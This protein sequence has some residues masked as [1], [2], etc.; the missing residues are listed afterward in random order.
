MEDIKYPEIAKHK[1]IHKDLLITLHNFVNT[2]NILTTNEIQIQLYQFID[3]YFVH[4]IMKEDIKIGMWMNPINT[5]RKTKKWHKEYEIGNIKFDKECQNIFQILEESF[6]EVD[7]GK[8]E[9]KIKSILTKLYKT[10]KKY[11]KIKEDFMEELNY[12]NIEYQKK[13]DYNCIENLNEL[14]KKVAKININL[15]EKELA[16]FIDNDI[17]VNIIEEDRRIIRLYKDSN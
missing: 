14:F 17:I 6:E 2:L 10:M 8:K 15:F 3:N 1:L 11:F 12:P 4:H 13:L 5:L 9:K 7:E 16:M